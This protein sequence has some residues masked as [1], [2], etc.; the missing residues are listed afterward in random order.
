MGTWYNDAPQEFHA[1]VHSKFAPHSVP[2]TIEQ[3]VKLRE[4]WEQGNA[5][6]KGE[7][8]GTDN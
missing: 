2:L 4:A 5:K 7:L 1:W 6:G 3:L 8:D